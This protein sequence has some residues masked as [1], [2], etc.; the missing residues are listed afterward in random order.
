MVS[1]VWGWGLKIVC[2]HFGDPVFGRL[3]RALRASVDQNCPESEF[4]E[5]VCDRPHERNGLLA[6]YTDNHSKLRIWRDSVQEAENDQR[7]V[8]IDADTIVL[9]DL[10]PA[11]DES[12]FDIGFTWRGGRLP[13]NSGVVYV[14]ANDRSR[15]FMDAW[16]K[17]DESLMQHRTLCDYGAHKYGGAN[18]ASFMWLWLHGGGPELADM[19][20]L[21]CRH[22]NSVDQ[23]WF[24]FDD[25]TRVLHIK[26]LLRELCL[27]NSKG[28]FWDSLK[29]MAPGQ[30]ETETRLEP[31]A[32][33]WRKYDRIAQAAEVPA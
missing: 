30:V 29:A 22:W 1:G 9:G 31:L 14:C 11:F 5:I 15:A 18:Q 32:K 33:L 16:V 20:P 21:M 7:L 3:A 27:G 26:G 6:H 28:E 17:R 12:D 8:L 4:I 24:Q 2:N 19:H 13:V 25:Q 10:S 23:T